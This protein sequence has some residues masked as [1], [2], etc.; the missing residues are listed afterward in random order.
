MAPVTPL[1]AD[2][3]IDV[4]SSPGLGVAHAVATLRASH[5]AWTAGSVNMLTGPHG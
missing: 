1:L 5:S 3:G 4:L 2:L